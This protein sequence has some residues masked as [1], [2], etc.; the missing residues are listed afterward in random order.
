MDDLAITIM[1]ERLAAGVAMGIMVGKE[2]K[3]K[4][5]VH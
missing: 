2:G 3:E 1:R 4:E 5:D